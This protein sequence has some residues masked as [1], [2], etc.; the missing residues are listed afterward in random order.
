MQRGINYPS[1]KVLTEFSHNLNIFRYNHRGVQ[2]EFHGP[3]KLRK[4]S[5]VDLREDIEMIAEYFC[6]KLGRTPADVKM[7]TTWSHM[8]GVN[9]SVKNIGWKRMLDGEQDL[10]DWLQKAIE[11]GVLSGDHIAEAQ[12]AAELGIDDDDDVDALAPAA[13]DDAADGG[14]L[15]DSGPADQEGDHHDAHMFLP[16][17]DSDLEP[18]QE[19]Q[20]EGE[21]TQDEADTLPPEPPK[22]TGRSARS[23]PGG[24]ADTSSDD[25]SS[26]EVPL[27]RRLPR[28]KASDVKKKT[29]GATATPDP[30]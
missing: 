3:A 5:V 24:T 19:P 22:K 23:V 2:E 28:D 6:K 8:A 12:L 27:I 1:E 18:D 9:I 16:V 13:E 4:E 14:A 21:D 10:R 7:R 20:S 29:A 15:G 17:T 25:D 30:H 11:T 26:D